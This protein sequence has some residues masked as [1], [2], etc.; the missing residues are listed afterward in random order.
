MATLALTVRQYNDARVRAALDR[1][2]RHENAPGRIDGPAPIPTYRVAPE[3]LAQFPTNHGVAER[4][5]R[6]SETT[7]I[8]LRQARRRIEGFAQARR[9]DRR[10]RYATP[11]AGNRARQRAYRARFRGAAVTRELPER[12]ERVARR[13]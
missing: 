10:R 3:P 9:A 5:N 6:Y 12:S 2:A 11:A 7:P 13:A 8:D 4:V 1:A